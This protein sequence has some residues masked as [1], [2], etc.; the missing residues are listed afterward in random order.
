M[1]SVPLQSPRAFPAV[2]SYWPPGPTSSSMIC[3]RSNWNG[4]CKEGPC[5]CMPTEETVEAQS[6]S[7]KRAEVEW[8][9]FASFEQPERALAVYAEENRRRGMLLRDLASFIGT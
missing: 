4:Y 9:N 2:T 1:A 7:V 8:H 3:A 6:L 5:R